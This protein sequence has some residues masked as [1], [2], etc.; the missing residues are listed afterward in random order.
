MG[1]LRAV[2]DSVS[3]TLA[4]QWK[5]I[6]TAG[7][8]TEHTVVAPGVLQASNNGRGTNYAGSDGVITN[9][10]KIFIPENTAAFI[11]SQ[12]RIENIVTEPG[13][14]EYAAGQVGVF[15]GD[16]VGT[17]VIGQAIDRVR[18]G[19]QTSD[20]K[21]VAFVNLREI[22]GL[23][24]GT[25][26]P[27]LY[28]DLFYGT[29]LEILAFGNFAVQVTVPERF[30]R[31]FVPPNVTSY[32]FDSDR[33]RAQ[34]SAEFL[35]SLID[36]LN[37]LSSTYRISQLPSQ[38]EEIAALITSSST[39]AGTWTERFGFELKAVAIE[40]IELTPESREL[41]KNY[42]SNR[43]N[44]K[45]YEGL[46]QDAS[47]I[48]AQQQLAQ[49]VQDHGLGDGGGLVLGMGLAQGMNPQTAASLSAAPSASPQPSGP[50]PPAVS[51]PA[52]PAGWYADPWDT[53]E[54]GG[55]RLRWWDGGQWTGHVSPPP[56]SRS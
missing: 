37:T 48:A 40:N 23:K 4:D 29:D 18:Y 44:L 8:F 7:S 38:V 45:A 6:I 35:Q 55:R 24:F 20:Q 26:G 31:N 17:S 25:R 2:T 5:D 27:L 11:F 30:I 47:N 32:S 15:D 1:I 12:S 53:G 39:N 34:I 36:T 46:S 13:G 54:G 42:S 41:V 3:G 56:P 51:V 16:G 49:G 28:H 14:Y 21:R 19:G 33:A 10:S 22:R 50:P 43:M 52:P 9:G